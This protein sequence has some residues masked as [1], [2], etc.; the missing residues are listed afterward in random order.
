MFN[1]IREWIKILKMEMARGYVLT[2]QQQDE[3]YRKKQ[4]RLE[5]GMIQYGLINKQDPVS[6][7]KDAYEYRKQRRKEKEKRD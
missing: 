3:K 5:P 7:M 1:K 6:F 4:A 2:V